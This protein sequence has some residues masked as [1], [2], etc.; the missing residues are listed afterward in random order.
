M[1]ETTLK[2]T[3]LPMEAFIGWAH[4]LKC[5]SREP[6]FNPMY[7][8][9][10][11]WK[12]EKSFRG[13]LVI[14]HPLTSSPCIWQTEN[15]CSHFSKVL[16]STTLDHVHSYSKLN[17]PSDW[18][19]QDEVA[20]LVG[21]FQTKCKVVG[22]FQT[23]CKAAKNR[24][25]SSVLIWCAGLEWDSNMP[26]PTC[27]NKVYLQKQ[28]QFHTFANILWSIVAKNR[29]WCA[30]LMC[31]SGIQTRN[32]KGQRAVWGK[33]FPQ[34]SCFR[35]TWWKELIFSNLL[36][37]HASNQMFGWPDQMN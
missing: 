36:Y 18:W 4:T 34:V 37:K 19:G 1:F 27:S 31:W 9:A 11:D 20:Q 23:K 12:G 5:L 28:H 22:L 30:A 10:Q 8:Q 33:S 21:L 26:W 6:Y 35:A 7:V 32:Q 16:K 17:Q 13:H 24:S 15:S 25:W 29:S 14:A 2:G 3:E